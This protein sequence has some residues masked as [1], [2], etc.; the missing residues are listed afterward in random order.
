MIYKVSSGMFNPT[1][2]LTLCKKT[3]NRLEF[4]YVSFYL[5][6]TVVKVLEFVMCCWTVTLL[7]DEF[8]F[9]V[10]H[11]LLAFSE[12]LLLILSAYTK[13]VCTVVKGFVYICSRLAK[14][15]CVCVW[16]THQRAFEA[17]HHN[18]HLYGRR[19][20]LEWADTESDTLDELRRKTAQHFVEGSSLLHC[21][22]LAP[23]AIM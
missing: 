4:H 15:W 2:S 22:N 10:L 14:L 20:V 3:L 21:S 11:C 5:F 23:A 19:L 9:H 7:S 17:L 18:T 1:Y 8:D 16:F 6:A 12:L 13:Y